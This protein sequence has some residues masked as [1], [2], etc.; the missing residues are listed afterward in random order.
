MTFAQ[1][2]VVLRARI[3]LVLVV[4]GAVIA[5]VGTLSV[6]LPKR[7]VATASLVVDTKAADP[8]TGALLPLQMLPV[9]LTTQLNIIESH[10]VALKVVDS[11]GLADLP[12]VREQFRTETAGAGSIRDWLADRLLEQLDVRPSR[13]SNMIQIAYSSIEPQ[14]AA[15]MSNA[16]ANAYIE[17]SLELKVD[18]ARRQTGWFEEQARSCANRSRPRKRNCRSTSATMRSWAMRPIA[19]TSRRCGSR[20]SRANSSARKVR[21]TRHA[22]GSGRW[23][24]P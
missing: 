11:L 20:S 6:V 18:P 3:W 2:L 24:N 17:T 21:C 23:T 10:S 12:A 7:Y 5:V 14:T 16:F 8:L 9:Y 19:S 1:I 22:P 13:D 4:L 15:D